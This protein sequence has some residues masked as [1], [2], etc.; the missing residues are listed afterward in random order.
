MYGAFSVTAITFWSFYETQ[1]TCLCF[2]TN[3]HADGVSNCVV[4]PDF[5]AIAWSKTRASQAT[6]GDH[7]LPP[8]A[9]S[10]H[11]DRPP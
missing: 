5:R 6:V 2:S 9:R 1:Q 8:M 3:N 11:M 10:Q 4:G 7:A